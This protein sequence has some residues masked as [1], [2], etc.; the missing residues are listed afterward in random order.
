MSYD[1]PFSKIWP[2]KCFAWQ[3]FK[4][5]FTYLV[6]KLLKSVCSISVQTYLQDRSSRAHLYPTLRFM[7][8]IEHCFQTKGRERWRPFDTAQL[9]LSRDKPDDRMNHV[10]P[11]P[12]WKNLQLKD[13]FTVNK[14]E[15]NAHFCRHGRGQEQT[16]H[17]S[18]LL[19]SMGSCWL[20]VRSSCFEALQMKHFKSYPESYS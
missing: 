18:S 3:N 6:T 17:L 12:T 9:V 15:L 11:L 14:R 20:L 16:S 10:L 4:N 13:V 2:L 19:L 1:L 7:R 8:I 5:S